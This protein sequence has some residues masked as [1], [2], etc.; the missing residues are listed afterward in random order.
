M[1]CLFTYYADTPLRRRQPH[2]VVARTPRHASYAVFTIC[3]AAILLCCCHAIVYSFIAYVTPCYDANIIY[4]M[5]FSAAFA[6]FAIEPRCFSPYAI[7]LLML[8]LRC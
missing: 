4:A 8:R 1:P 3:H 6:A 2:A 5:L 7:R